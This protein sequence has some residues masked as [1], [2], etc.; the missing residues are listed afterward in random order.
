M[1]K[2]SFIHVHIQYQCD[3]SDPINV[4]MERSLPVFMEAFLPLRIIDECYAMDGLADSDEVLIRSPEV[5][6]KI[7]LRQVASR[8]MANQLA[9]L[10]YNA[11]GARDTL[12]GDPVRDRDD[13]D[14]PL[15]SK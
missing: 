7:Q 4:T 2:K 11:M 5:K 12:N 13:P 10:L 3:G 1:S 15:K 6:R 9:G 14:Y 8:E